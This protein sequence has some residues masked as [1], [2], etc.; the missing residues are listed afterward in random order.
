MMLGLGLGLTM[1]RPAAGGGGGFILRGSDPSANMGTTGDKFVSPSGS[2]GNPGTIGSPYLTLA[3]AM[4]QLT[5]GQHLKVRAGTYRE[6]LSFSGKAGTVGNNTKVSRYG[7]EVVTI[8]AQNAV[9][10]WTQCGAG[11]AT[12]LGAVL[13]VASSPVYKKTMLKT[14]ANLSGDPAAAFPYEN[15]V[16]LNAAMARIADPAK[17]DSERNAGDW[18]TATATVQSAGLITGYR[19]AS[20]TSAYTSAQLL[21]TYT[22]FYGTPNA[23]YRTKTASIGL[24][25]D[26]IANTINLTDQTQTY[27]AGT[28][29]ADKF[30][31][32]NLLPAL[33]PGSWGYTI[34]NATDCTI[35]IYPNSSANM[36]ANITMSQRGKCIDFAGQNYVE[37]RGLTC[38]GASWS[39]G[40][41]DGN[42]AITGGGTP[43]KNTVVV[44]NCLVENT[45]RVEEDYGSIW[46][47]NYDNW[48]ISR[49]TVRN[50]YNQFGVFA[51]GGAFATSGGQQAYGGRM[52]RCL[53]ENVDKSPYRFYGQFEAIASFSSAWNCGLASHANKSNAYEGCH[54][55]IW[56][57]MDFQGCDG[58]LTWQEASSVVVA[59][60]HVPVSNSDSDGRG[61]NDQNHT[62]AAS[63]ATQLNINGDSYILN[64]VVAPWK[65]ALAFTNSLTIGKS[66]SPDETN[67]LFAGK[68]NILHGASTVDQTRLITNGWRNN[69]LTSGSALAASSGTDTT[70]LHTTVYNDVNA[71]NLSIKIDSPSRSATTASI[72]AEIAVLQGWFPSFTGFGLDLTGVAYTAAT[73]PMG[74]YVNPDAPNTIKPLWVERPSI[75]GTPING[76]VL[77]TTDGYLIG[78]PY[79][80]VTYQWERSLTGVTWANVASLGNSA[81]YIPVSG[82]IGY[83][84]RRVA[85]ATNTQ[86]VAVTKTVAS[87]A[88]ISSYAL[89]DPVVLT[90]KQ[91]PSIGGASNVKQIETSA[92]AVTGKP[93]IV[94]ISQRN[95]SSADAT[96]TVTYGAS[97]RAFGAGTSLGAVRGRS[98]RTGNETQV[99]LVASP[100][101]GTITVQAE[102][103]LQTYGVDIQVIEVAGATDVNLQTVGGAT[104]VTS[105]TFALTTDTINSGALWINN[106]FSGDPANPVSMTG[107]DAVISNNNTG[108]N[109]TEDLCIT[110]GYE[111]AASIGAYAA[112][113]SWPTAA[114]V[115]TLAMQVKS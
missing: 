108:A 60:S 23:T 42:Y 67:V 22:L 11:D 40:V 94:V 2:D 85:T 59:F 54:R 66:A 48:L 24:G 83:M 8:D 95:A 58:Y 74:P 10:G 101:T 49:T 99:F 79:P 70:A 109:V 38:R 71:G 97:G 103:S 78:W 53:A 46:L 82:D 18:L 20:L 91:A 63:P 31:L 32:I 92:F 37:A 96:L 33:V 26:G 36:A 1:Q 113:A 73:P 6:T 76:Q 13:G 107:V 30:A 90:S 16:K 84:L 56:W 52:D 69:L 9:T 61:I 47:G 89:G 115:T 80:S 104:T 57:G 50:I 93:I 14:A 81:S 102:S 68:N 111:K 110:I 3:Y 77:G 12:V 98:R 19:L 43:K 88:V 72:A 106:R 100:G 65:G 5:S 87:A 41:T 51:Q 15:G 114:T 55:F 44:D 62:S 86:G 27:N 34:D 39:G 17:P 75:S 35:Y 25:T 64:N 28:P 21:N 7:T 112:A 29:N 45:Y 4:S 105:R